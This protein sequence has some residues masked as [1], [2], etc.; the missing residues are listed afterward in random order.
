MPKNQLNFALHMSVAKFGIAS[1]LVQYKARLLSRSTI[2]RKKFAV[3]KTRQLPN[4]QW[5][6][7]GPINLEMKEAQ[8]PS[9]PRSSSDSCPAQLYW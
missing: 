7:D 6:K 1:L 8:R 2:M 4:G 3:M 9:L 5:I